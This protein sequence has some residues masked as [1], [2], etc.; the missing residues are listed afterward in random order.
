MTKTARKRR[1]SLALDADLL[2]RAEELGLDLQRVVESALRREVT[3]LEAIR[4]EEATQAS[5]DRTMAYWNEY[6][7]QGLSVADEYGTLD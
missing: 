6:N 2:S 7:R 4:D 1:V 3:R 5:M